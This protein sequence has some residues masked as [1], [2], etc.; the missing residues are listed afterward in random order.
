VINPGLISMLTLVKAFSPPKV[1]V[2][3]STTKAAVMS[4]HGSIKV[5][6]GLK[7]HGYQCKDPFPQAANL[8]FEGISGDFE[9]DQDWTAPHT[10][11]LNSIF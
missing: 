3:L 10:P 7:S 8:E 5:V 4:T 9:R 11:K 6:N 1:R 2:T